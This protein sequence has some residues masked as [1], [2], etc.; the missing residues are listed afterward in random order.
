M[1]RLDLGVEPAEREAAAAISKLAE[2]IEEVCYHLDA[3]DVPPATIKALHRAQ[4]ILKPA[5]EFYFGDE[6]P[7]VWEPPDYKF[8]KVGKC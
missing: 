2:S 1:S 4:R 8:K 7:L 6:S 3:Q 5:T